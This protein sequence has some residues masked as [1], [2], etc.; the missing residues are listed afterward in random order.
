MAVDMIQDARATRAFTPVYRCK[1]THPGPLIKEN[2]TCK[3]KEGY[4][5]FKNFG[6]RG[7]DPLEGGDKCNCNN[8]KAALVAACW[9]FDN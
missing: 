2:L 6:S 1:C 7:A 5:L 8:R 3:E 4:L 9:N